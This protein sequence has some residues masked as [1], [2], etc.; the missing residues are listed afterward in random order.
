MEE[1]EEKRREKIARME[2]Q[3]SLDPNCATCIKYFYTHKDID[4]WYPRHKASDRCES[5]KRSHC[6]CDV[7]W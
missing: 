3:G 1:T 6:T 2:Q 7:C 5:G 4:P